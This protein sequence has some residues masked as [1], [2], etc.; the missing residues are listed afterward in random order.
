MALPFVQKDFDTLVEDYK[1]N[2]AAQFTLLS[3]TADLSDG[4]LLILIGKP[5][6]FLVEEM[7]EVAASI[8][9]QRD[10]RTATGEFLDAI[11]F[12]VDVVRTEAVKSTGVVR[13][14]R[15]VAAL[16]NYPIPAGTQI[17]TTPDAFGN[18]IVFETTA[19]VTLTIGN[20]FVDAPARALVAGISGNVAAARITT[21]VSSVLG[22]E[23]VTNQLP[24][25]NGVDA[26]GDE[27]YRARIIYRMQNPI[28]GGTETDLINWT[29]EVSGS[30]KAAVIREH[31]GI[32]TAD[33]L[34]L[35]ND[36]IP[37]TFQIHTVQVYIDA[38]KYIN[39][40]ILVIAPTA[41]AVDVTAVITEYV[42]GF[43]PVAVRA[44]VEDS[45][46]AY[47]HS[48][49]L[50]ASGGRVRVVGL[51]NA[52]FVTPGVKNFTMSVPTADHILTI[53]EAAIPGTIT[54]T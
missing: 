46:E 54:I 4:T 33:I 15:G 48:L 1:T 29:L 28:Q 34:F 2:L 6:A 42:Q 26:E 23:T 44:A 49:A 11:A 52:I 31:R 27:A 45:L 41:Y 35:F 16:I 38:R 24:F 51:E 20:T 19:A 3:V 21:I 40:D 13:F 39:A 30:T 32:G 36:G 50:G 47:I 17:S 37:T 7:Y 8:L 14:S 9:F 25:E 22:P 5:I 10:V 43:D 18:A 53:E 12:E